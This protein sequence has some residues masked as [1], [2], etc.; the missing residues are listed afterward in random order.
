M[1]QL[2]KMKVFIYWDNIYYNIAKNLKGIR[3]VDKNFY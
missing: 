3:A 1:V 2:P